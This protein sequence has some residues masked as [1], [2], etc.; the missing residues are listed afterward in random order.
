M[1]LSQA[2]ML[3]LKNLLS[4]IEEPV[5]EEQDDIKFLIH[6][7]FAGGTVVLFNDKEGIV[8]T[9]ERDGT[10][11]VWFG[12]LREIDGAKICQPVNYQLLTIK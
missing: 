3:L 8:D 1:T 7:K 5:V 2:E 12:E 11:H 10:V 6:Q 9:M 4:K